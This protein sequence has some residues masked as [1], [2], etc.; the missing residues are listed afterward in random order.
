MMASACCKWH[1]EW[2]A[3]R[4][5]AHLVEIQ[6]IV[7]LGALAEA[8]SEIVLIDALLVVLRLAEGLH[9]D[10]NGAAIERLGSVVV[11]AL[12][13]H[14]ALPAESSESG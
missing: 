14:K 8:I 7:K 11:R 3:R 2:Q 1:C 4:T 9:D 13:Q 5:C 6:R 10:R 12:L